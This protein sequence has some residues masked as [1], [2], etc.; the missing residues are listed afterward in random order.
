MIYFYKNILDNSLNF[1]KLLIITL[2][3][4]F[5]DIKFKLFSTLIDLRL[6]SLFLFLIMLYEIRSLKKIS[7]FFCWF[8]IFLLFHYFLN[9]YI[10]KIPINLY[11][12]IKIISAFLILSS[13]YYYK[14]FILKNFNKLIN[15]FLIIFFLILIV[16][17]IVNFFNGSFSINCFFGCFS[18]NRFL[19]LENSHLAYISSLIIFY[20]IHNLLNKENVKYFPFFLFFL[21]SLIKNQ[22][23]TLLVS[24]ILIAAFF[25]IF[26]AKK[27]NKLKVISFLCIFVVS[28]I[29]IFKALHKEKV[30]DFVNIILDKKDQEKTT[31]IFTP[32][33]TSH[34]KNLSSDVYFFNFKIA[35]NS[36]V[37]RPF[38]WGLFNYQSA[39]NKYSKI[40]KSY[41]EGSSWLNN[42]DGSNILF[43]SMVELG[44]FSLILWVPFL[45]FLFNRKIDFHYKLLIAPPVITQVL[46][47]G[48]GFFNGGIIV[49][50]ILYFYLL[51]KKN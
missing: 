20:H 13:I 45:F 44:I 47:R 33:K 19:Y 25:L 12:I 41:L 28:I 50:I 31:L 7:F 22:S 49:F 9:I 35:F 2:F 15:L 27:I 42:N 18:I 39:H 36:L 5:F 37:D 8:F 29:F 21:I 14:E 16:S 17:N 30:D 1:L 46:I 51:F 4:F 38:G 11:L 10:N 40:T 43:K 34:V 24:N 48:S 3:I 23:T 6:F 26:F 32:P